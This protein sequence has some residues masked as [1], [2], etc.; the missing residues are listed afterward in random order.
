MTDP[1][2]TLLQIGAR[3]S[4]FPPNSRYHGI[5]VATTAR[6]D[7]T[8]VVYLRRRFAPPPGAL[9]AVAEHAVTDG[10]R[11]DNLAASYLG[12]PEL[13][14]RLCDANGAMHPETLT[15]RVGR[16]LRVALPEGMAAGGS[17]D[18]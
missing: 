9:D 5:E 2:Q 1:L 3:A 17:S 15:A 14:W 12:D 6:P 16:L 18:A 10:D 8:P 13:F 11:L 7:G 4:R